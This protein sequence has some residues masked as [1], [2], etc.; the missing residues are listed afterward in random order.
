MLIIPVHM[1]CLLQITSP[2][3][4]SHMETI[5]LSS[6]SILADLVNEQEAELL[7]THSSLFKFILQKLDNA[8]KEE[9]H[10]DVGWS[11]EE[12]TRGNISFYRPDLFD[13]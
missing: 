10:K 6:I 12:L 2:Y 3:L 4:D 11:A 9:S 7:V 5:R 1:C 8:L 13:L